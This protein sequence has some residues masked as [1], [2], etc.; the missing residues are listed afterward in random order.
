MRR[1]IIAYVAPAWKYPLGLSRLQN[2]NW[3][4]NFL[5]QITMIVIATELYYQK[6]V[7]Q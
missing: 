3:V 4:L 6:K 2:R 5:G 1:V 7:W